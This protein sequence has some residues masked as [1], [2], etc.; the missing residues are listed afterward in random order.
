MTVLALKC[1]GLNVVQN[2]ILG[3]K[4]EPR[5]MLVCSPYYKTK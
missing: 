3:R 2:E 5:R 4:W 1:N